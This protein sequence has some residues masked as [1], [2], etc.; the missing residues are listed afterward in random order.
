MTS[1]KDARSQRQAR[2][3][4]HAH[5]GVAKPIALELPAQEDGQMHDKAELPPLINNGDKVQADMAQKPV[6]LA[7]LSKQLRLDDAYLQVRSTPN[8]GRV[9]YAERQ[10]KAGQFTSEGRVDGSGAVIYTS[11]ACPPATALST[12]YLTTHCSTCFLSA[13]DAA[14]LRKRNEESM[15][16][17]G[18]CKLVHYCSSVR[19]AGLASSSELTNRHVSWRT[20]QLTSPSARL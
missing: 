6:P 5:H 8:A 14:V 17:C 10:Y 1:F 4:P 20:G 19:I 15:K 18:A 3:A 9:L 2:Q 13:E 7:D 12:Q 11:P 16:R